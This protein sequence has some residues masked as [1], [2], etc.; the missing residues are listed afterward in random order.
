[1]GGA[2]SH[3]AQWEAEVVN[4]RGL[5]AGAGNV[6]HEFEEQLKKEREQ[7][8]KKASKTM[9]IVRRQSQFKA[10][11]QQLHDAKMKKALR[12]ANAAYPGSDNVIPEE[13]DEDEGPASIQSQHTVVSTHLA[14]GLVNTWREIQAKISVD[15]PMGSSFRNHI[16]QTVHILHHCFCS[17]VLDTGLQSV[18][19][20][21]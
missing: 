10:Q 9:E 19:C 8:E 13:D 18:S 21:V 12:E 11:M 14:P 17:V 7:E 20:T 16:D 15:A 3:T 6:D 4:G 5:G 2:S 1:M